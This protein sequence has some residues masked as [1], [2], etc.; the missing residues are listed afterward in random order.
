MKKILMLSV[1]CFCILAVSACR[2]RTI[3]DYNRA[4]P[5]KTKAQIE[6]AI[7]AGCKDRGWVCQKTSDGVINGVLKPGSRYI[8][9]NI[10]Y[11]DNKYT[12]VYVKTEKLKDKNKGKVHKRYYKW[13]NYLHKSIHTELYKK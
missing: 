3:K 5:N 4:M 6:T 2:T 1:M 9:V 10:V 11:E 12:I 8:E 13:L 7:F